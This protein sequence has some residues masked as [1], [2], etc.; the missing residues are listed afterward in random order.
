LSAEDLFAEIALDVQVRGIA[1]RLFTYEIPENLRPEVCIG[2][3]VLVPFG[4]RDL[5]P[6]YVVSIRDRSQIIAGAQGD[7]QAGKLPEKI[8]PISEVLDSNSLFEPGY[9]EFLYWVSEY[10]LCSIAEVLSAAVP[11]GAAPRVRRLVRLA[12]GQTVLADNLLVGA[13][14]TSQAQS[15][16]AK[17]KTTL[18]SAGK[19]VLLKTLKERLSLSNQV[20]YATLAKL[21]RAGEIVVYAEKQSQTPA[22]LRT[23]LSA[24][25]QSARTHRQ[26]EILNCLAGHNNSMKQTDLIAECKCTPAT[27]RRMVD[28]GIL[29]VRQVEEVRDPVKRLQASAYEKPPLTESQS[30]VLTVLSAQLAESLRQPQAAA[31]ALE[32]P[33]LLHGVT[34]S[35]KTEIYLRLIEE[36]LA[37]NRAALLLVPEISLTPQLSERLIGRF[38]NKVGIWHSALSAGERVDTFKRI[39]S[40]ELKLVMGARSAILA[41][42]PGLGLIILDE[43]HDGSYKQSTP[44]PRYCARQLATRRARAQGCFVLF[45][46]ATPDACTYFEAVKA[47]RVVS[48]PGRVFEQALPESC[49]VDMRHEFAAGNRSAISLKLQEELAGCLARRE[50]A[51]LLINRRGYASH[52]FCRACGA[53]LKCNHCSVS[54]VFHAGRRS[55]GGVNPLTS[56]TLSCHHCGFSQNSGEVCPSC[57]S[58]FLRQAGLGTQKIEEETRELLP[59]ARLLRLDSDTTSGRGAYE[60]IFHQ[61]SGQA[62]DILIG[63]QMVAKGLDI[64]RVTLVG[65]LAADA[66][67]N[68]P[69]FRSLERGFQLLTQVSGR[70]GRGRSPGKVILQ[71]YN[72]DLPALLL[73]RAQDYNAFIQEELAARQT[74]SYPPFSRLVRIVGSGPDDGQVQAA[75]ER[76]AEEL[77]N[78]LEEFESIRILGPAPC[79]IEKIKEHYRHH[80]IVKNLMGDAGHRAI[81]SFLRARPQLPGVRLIVDVD[82]VDLI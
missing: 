62:A 61:F 79:L 69:D 1:G 27:I 33:W 35:G 15:A 47:K 14:E 57:H 65:V 31:G 30:Q 34:G 36:T 2:S 32:S 74:F 53:V 22:R 80:I 38:G 58:P 71:T 45:G 13:A 67:F 75:L 21:R 63:T 20:F 49:L 40:G 42:I 51:I 12:E 55:A 17:I 54:L 28:E 18:A 29:S 59:E 7:R 44:S 76:L 78:H 37:S 19:S 81:V 8:R 5:L 26:Q 72:T 25:A 56:G 4:A 70:A 68:L 23:I 10:Y 3:Q 77:S 50:Q 6:G 24:T 39:Q 73:A 11:P 48:L 60:E 46:S 9:I 16:A 82:P 41:N 64:E 66:A 52:V 43:E